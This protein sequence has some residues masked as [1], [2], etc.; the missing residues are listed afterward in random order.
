MSLDQLCQDNLDAFAV[1]GP[2]PCRRVAVTFG[3]KGSM[4]GEQ[5]VGLSIPGMREIIAGMKD[6][7]P[8]LRRSV[9]IRE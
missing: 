8:Q 9:F 5:D 3:A 6:T 4:C 1:K 7:V 2:P